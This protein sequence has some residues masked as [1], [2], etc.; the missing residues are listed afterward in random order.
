MFSRYALYSWRKIYLGLGSV[1][2]FFPFRS[3]NYH[4]RIFLYLGEGENKEK[5]RK[6]GWGLG[7]GAEH[8]M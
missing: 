6:K 2:A 3:R 1:W 8:G 7:S 4:T 5:K